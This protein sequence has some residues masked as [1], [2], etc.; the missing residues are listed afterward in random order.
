MGLTRS[1][2]RYVALIHELQRGGATAPRPAGRLG[3]PL[4]CRRPGSR[5]SAWWNTSRTE[6][7]SSPLRE[8]VLRRRRETEQSRERDPT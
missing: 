6:G 4:V 1:I 7:R 5:G 8:R 2:R 3:S